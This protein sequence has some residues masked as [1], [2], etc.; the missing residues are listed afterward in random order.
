V[1][2]TDLK[3][4]FIGEGSQKDELQELASKNKVNVVFLGKVDQKKITRGN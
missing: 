4:V 2:G 3:I 1:L